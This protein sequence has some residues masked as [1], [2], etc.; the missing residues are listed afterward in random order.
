[1]AGI[2]ADGF[3]VTGHRCLVA[4]PLEVGAV[5]RVL[6]QVE[7]AEAQGFSGG[8]W[9]SP[10]AAVPCVFEI[11]VGAVNCGF[12]HGWEVQA[13]AAPKCAASRWA[14]TAWARVWI[15]R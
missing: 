14:T 12:G 6:A 11:R 5:K 13:Q 9:K 7:E 10:E 15:S 2:D 1:M 4:A 3:P 8:W